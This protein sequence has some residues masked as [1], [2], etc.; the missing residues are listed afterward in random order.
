[1]MDLKQAIDYLQPIADN[2]EIAKHGEAMRIALDAMR[3]AERREDSGK[4]YR[5]ALEVFGDSRQI[6]KTFEEIGEFM[7][8]LIKCKYGRDKMPHLAEE[9][10]DVHIMLDQMAVLFG[11][12]EEVERMKRYKIRRLEQRIEEVKADHFRDLTKM[13]DTRADKVR[14]MSDREIALAMMEFFVDE[15]IKLCQ[16]K[17]ECVAAMD[18][19]DIVPDDKCVE[20]LVA[21][22]QQPAEEVQGDG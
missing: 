10:A 8:A 7:E 21:W 12:A 2:T 3:D 16:D 14:V 13:V 11:C 4:L 1:M 18:K 20:C 15:H 19:G 17:P 5:V 9:M 22:L 6:E